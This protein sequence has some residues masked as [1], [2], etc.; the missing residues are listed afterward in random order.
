[1]KRYPYIFL[2]M[3]SLLVVVSC[4]QGGQKA[5]GEEQDI[6]MRYATLLRMK[7]GDGYVAAE[8]LNPWDSTR[9]L[10]RYVLVPRD[11]ELPAKLPEGDVIRTPLR[12]MLVYVSVHSSLFNELGALDAI[13]A[14]GDGQYMY[15]DRLQADIKSGKVLDC[16]TS[17]AINVEQIIDFDPDAVIISAMEDNNSYA[18]LLNVGIPV[19]ECADYMETGPL[20]RAEWMRFYGLLVGKGAQADSLFAAIEHDYNSLKDKVKDIPHKPTVLDGKKLNSSWYVAGAASTTGQMITDAGGQYVFLDETSNGSVPYSPEVVLDRGI[21]ADIWMLKYYKEEGE[22]ML[23][24]LSSDWTGYT[25][26]KAYREKRVYSVNLSH[27]DFYMVTP[28]HPEVLLKE[29]I[30]I[31]HPEVVEPGFIPTYYKR[32]E[33]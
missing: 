14:V 18:K 1:M 21:D 25:R 16:G 6:E 9:V 17:N 31:C 33:E 22:P 12:K 3:L 2:L 20:Q 23:S 10:H 24:D 30:H 27:T 8:F 13:G 32:I 28:F 26:L 7:E 19:V 15:I 5:A 4:R 29:Y 11:A